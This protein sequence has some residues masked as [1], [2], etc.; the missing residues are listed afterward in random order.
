M[1]QTTTTDTVAASE[2][3]TWEPPIPLEVTR[4]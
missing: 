1:R 4:A 3:Y 2:S